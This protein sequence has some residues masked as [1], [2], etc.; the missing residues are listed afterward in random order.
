MKPFLAIFASFLFCSS[1]LFGQNNQTAVSP[2][3][4]QQESQE[5]SVN[6]NDQPDSLSEVETTESEVAAPTEEEIASLDSGNTAWMITATALVLFM[7]LPGL[8]LFYGG[9]VQ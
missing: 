3:P 1:T 2:A 4:E 9:L 5:S 8:A 7:T 6:P